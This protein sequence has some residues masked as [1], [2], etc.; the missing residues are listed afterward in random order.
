MILLKIYAI[1]CANM[2]TK[3]LGIGFIKASNTGKQ[4]KLPKTMLPAEI[5]LVEDSVGPV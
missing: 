2:L 4:Q 1:F 3:G 5:K